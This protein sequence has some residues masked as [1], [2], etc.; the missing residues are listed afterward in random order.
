LTFNEAKAASTEHEKRLA[1][2]TNPR[3]AEQVFDDDDPTTKGIIMGKGTDERPPRQGRRRF[4]HYDAF[5][6]ATVPNADGTVTVLVRLDDNVTKLT[7]L[8]PD[9]VEAKRYTCP[10][11]LK[12]FTYEKYADDRVVLQSVD[13]V[14]QPLDDSVPF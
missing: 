14:V 12:D 5:G 11:C 13:P 2:A 7:R 8:A 1:G 3:R 6:R 10:C 4:I 9:P